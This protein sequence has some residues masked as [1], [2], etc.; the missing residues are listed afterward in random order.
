VYTKY[1]KQAKLYSRIKLG[2]FDTPNTYI[3]HDRSISQ[4][5]E[6]LRDRGS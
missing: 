1:D 6:T 3:V 2:K 5:A 4:P